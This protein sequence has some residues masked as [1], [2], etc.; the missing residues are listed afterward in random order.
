MN[1]VGCLK[2]VSQLV[3]LKRRIDPGPLSCTYPIRPS[4][5]PYTRGKKQGKQGRLVI[6]VS[7][8][9]VFQLVY[10]NCR[11]NIDPESLSHNHYALC[12][13]IDEGNKAGK[14][15]S[16]LFFLL[17]VPKCEIFDLMDSRDFYTIKPL[18]VGDFGTV[19]KKS[20][21]FFFEDSGGVGLML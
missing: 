3:Y 15:K 16:S 6:V 14:A 20:K 5:N 2:S 12:I 4:A 13:P 11:I 18:W 8:Q 10:L 19:I 9:S 1:A 17:K 7:L 21:F